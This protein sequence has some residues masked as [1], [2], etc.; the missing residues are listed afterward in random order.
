MNNIVACSKCSTELVKDAKFCHKCGTARGIPL[1]LFRGEGMMGYGKRYVKT[2]EVRCPKKGELYLS[3]ALPTAYKAP[4]DL[5][6]KF[7]IMRE[8]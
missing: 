3:G 6:T 4:N 7:N 2:G 5:S 1:Q 8:V